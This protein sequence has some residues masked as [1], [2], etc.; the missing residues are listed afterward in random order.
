MASPCGVVY[1]TGCFRAGPP[2][3]TRLLHHRGLCFPPK[4]DPRIIPTF[5]CEACQVR[6]FLN[7]ELHLR[8]F[9]DLRLLQFERVRLLDMLHKWAA[10]TLAQYRGQIRRLF[11]FHETFGVNPL[12]P[13]PLLRPPTS[14]AIPLM[15]AQLEYTLNPGKK[16]GSTVKFNTSRQ[17]RSAAALYYAWDMHLTQS[18]K[19]MMG[20]NDRV[21]ATSQVSPTDAL[22]Y[23]F[24]QLGMARRMGKTSSQSWPLLFKHIL[25]MDQQFERMWE[26]ASDDL[27]RWEV[28]TAALANLVFWGSW[29]R[30]GE[31]F[32]LKV[33]DVEVHGPETGPLFDLPVGVGHIGLRLLPETKTNPFRVADVVMAYRFA[34][35][36]CP[37]LWFERKFLYGSYDGVS[38]FS[39]PAKRQWDSG[40]FRQQY[41][42][43]LLELMRM[44]GE[45]TL[46]CF[47][48]GEQ[49][50]MAIYEM[51]SWRGGARTFTEHHHPGINIRA[52][53]KAERQEHARWEDKRDGRNRSV[54]MDT[55]YRTWGLDKRLPITLF[56]S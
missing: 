9:S 55:H 46:Q 54:D 41:V 13:S 10:G 50:R 48:D 47:V 16:E 34:S 21:Y 49:L 44:Q 23:T 36:L 45:P 28:A 11:R 2:F 35:G 4:C 40:Y 32:G 27:T 12:M 8:L 20:T 39:T 1:H 56:C 18:D 43:P 51:R 14:P 17:L 33:S 26:S 31:G 53:T 5:V 42:Y 15:W 7:R 24:Q 22:S 3:K 30:G 25:F 37:G 38:L 29:L 6:V 19:T 52:S